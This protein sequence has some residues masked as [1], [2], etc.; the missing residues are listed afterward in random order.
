[1]GVD[2]KRQRTKGE[3]V[4]VFISDRDNP[5][6]EWFHFAIEEMIAKEEQDYNWLELVRNARRALEMR[7]YG[8]MRRQIRLMA[9]I[10]GINPQDSDENDN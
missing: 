3:M 4:K 7:D 8:E 6:W 10:V 2:I 9:S 5:E 1:M